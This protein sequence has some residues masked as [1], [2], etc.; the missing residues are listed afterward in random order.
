MIL[1]SCLSAHED[2]WQQLCEK[3]AL[4]DALRA[5]IVAELG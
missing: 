1:R 3:K 2:I 5:G 4:D